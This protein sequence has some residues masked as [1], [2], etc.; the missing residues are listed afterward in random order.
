MLRRLFGKRRRTTSVIDRER[1]AIFDLDAGE[2]PTETVSAWM[3]LGFANPLPMDDD[4][5]FTSIPPDG[6]MGFS[7]NQ[8]FDPEDSQ[9]RAALFGTSIAMAHV[10]VLVTDRRILWRPINPKLLNV[11]GMGYPVYRVPALG[12]RGIELHRVLFAESMGVAQPIEDLPGG[13]SSSLFVRLEIQSDGTVLRDGSFPM[14][15]PE[16]LEGWPTEGDELQIWVGEDVELVA[17]LL[18]IALD[19]VGIDVVPSEWVEAA[20][21]VRA[22]WRPMHERL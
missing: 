12:Q 22:N 4:A 20:R 1:L 9:T 8:W 5:F 13:I 19:S 15:L 6:A 3:P 21:S 16:E 10:L 7:R 2:K 14:W 17:D 11:R 18:A